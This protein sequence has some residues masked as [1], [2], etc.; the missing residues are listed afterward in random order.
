[1]IQPVIVMMWVCARCNGIKSR[2]AFACVYVDTGKQKKKQ[3]KRNGLQTT[4][5]IYTDANANTHMH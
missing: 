2:Y 5:I 1:M 3:C 4:L